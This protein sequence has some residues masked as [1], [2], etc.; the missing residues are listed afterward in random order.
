M[1][2]IRPPL[3]DPPAGAPTTS[4]G[5]S[6]AAAQE[7]VLASAL[8]DGPTGTVGLELEGHLVDLADP[9]SLVTWDRVCST[10]ASLPTLPRSSRVTVEPG[11]QVELSTLAGPGADAAVDAL[12]LDEVA[13]RSH[14]RER[15]LG[16]AHLGADPARPARRVNPDPRYAA[17][18]SYFAATGNQA[19]GRTMMCST[20]AL[21]VNV[22]AGPAANWSR[23]VQLAHA[24][25]P[26]LVAI[27][28]CSPLLG[29]EVT[30]WRSSRA[31]VWGDLD[32]ARGR[33]LRTGEDPAQQWA[34]YA[35]GSPVM[36]VRD[37][38]TG[39][40]EPINRPVP[41]SSWVTGEALLGGRLPTYED[42]DYHLTTLFPPV[43]LR[44][45]LEIR[46]LDAVPTRWWP[47]LAAITVALL[48]DP[49]A[50]DKAAAATEAVAGRWS[51]AARI[52]LADPL[53]AAAARSCVEAA[54]HAVPHRLKPDVER[55]AEL[56]HA[57]RTPGDEVLDLAS[58]LGPL[59][60]LR[61]YADA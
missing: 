1:P 55:Y 18:E 21:Q 58:K 10:V 29:G 51:S 36:L 47:A 59:L 39:A 13:L 42:L 32:Q 15:G 4:T 50:A 24:L 19:A 31:R 28:A 12:G 22:E 5:L 11:G 6:L 23:R 48:D 56:V 27:S 3:T 46:Y 20:A 44:G 35:L 54:A 52:G 2:A 57:G 49:A 41:F 26:V 61:K 8:R 9:A 37:P 16:V 45:F 43:R 38:A 17:M 25:G 53:V 60:A 30:G 14:L 34:T 33:L 7:C 40:A